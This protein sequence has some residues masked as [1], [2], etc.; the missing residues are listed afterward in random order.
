[1]RNGSPQQRRRSDRGTARVHLAPRP[2]AVRRDARV[3]WGS[4]TALPEA[5]AEVWKGR[6]CMQ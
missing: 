6:T 1:V 4:L 3:E 5:L 2:P